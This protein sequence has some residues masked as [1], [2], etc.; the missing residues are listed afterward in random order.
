MSEQRRVAI[1]GS[2]NWG[3]A[4]AAVIGGNL[5]KEQSKFYREVRMWTFE[6]L[7][8]GRK[9]TDIINQD[10]E[11]VKYLP[12]HKLPENVIAEPDILKA[13]E[14][15]DLLVFVLPN[16]IFARS[17]E[18]LVGKVK[19]GAI[20]LSLVKGL[21]YPEPGKIG[22]IS[23]ILRE[24]LGVEVGVLMGA[25]IANEVAAGSFC[26][27]TIAFKNVEHGRLFRDAIQTEN[28]RV[29]VVNDV[30]NA[31]LSGALKNIVAFAA[32]LIDGLYGEKARATKA[33]VIRLGIM[34]MIDF[35]EKF[36]PGGSRDTFLE[37]C[38]VADVI[39]SSFG[40][41]NRKCAEAFAKQPHKVSNLF[42]QNN[43]FFRDF[44]DNFV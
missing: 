30:A 25:N 17:C 36:F 3:S 26:E 40:G 28:F 43:Q 11:N 44:Y 19:S 24:Q 27:A 37:S 7:I 9:L 33:A 38:G 35:A 1:V 14:D 21:N 32:G 29:T 10:H 6:E 4:I 5:Q 39:T 18:Q 8:N 34:E 42:L 12:G 15:A 22:L 31:E 13:T 20:A 23:D 41:H 2:G 16:Q